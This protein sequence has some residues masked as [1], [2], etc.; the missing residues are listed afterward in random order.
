MGHFTSIRGWL[1]LDEDMVPQVQK[2]VEAAASN[3]AI[4]TTEQKAIQ[5]YAQGWVFP[6]RHVN[7]TRYV[8][9][10][11]DVRTQ[12]IGLLKDQLKAVSELVST[13]GNE[14]EDHPTGLFYVD[15]EDG[16]TSLCWEIGDGQFRETMRRNRRRPN[17]GST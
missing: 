2:L 10:G 12:H 5:L 14:F 6:T 17:T 15:D 7:W 13:L 11:A 3:T 1:E 9:Y 4:S 8:F 16:A